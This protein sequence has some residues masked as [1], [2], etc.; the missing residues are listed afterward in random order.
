MTRG[1]GREDCVE[2]FGQFDVDG[3]GYA[4][5]AAM[6]ETLKSSNGANLKGELTHVI[7][8]LQTC[9]LTPGLVDV[10]TSERESV[11]H[12]GKRLVKYVLRNRAP[13][14]GLPFFYLDGFNNII[15]MRL[16][17][18]GKYLNQKQKES[19]LKELTE[20]EGGII[21]VINKCYKWIRVSTSSDSA[22][23]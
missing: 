9:S 14:T 8:T 7:R 1:V 2:A 11:G 6:L 17:V 12:Q 22:Q 5:V 20:E 18:L 23:W 15:T 19:A 3:E 21:K 4:E 13:S 16:S 10:Y